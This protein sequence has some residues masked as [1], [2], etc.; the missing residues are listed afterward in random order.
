MSATENANLC[1]WKSCSEEQAVGKTARD[2]QTTEETAK[3]NKRTD[4][5]TA[6]KRKE[7]SPEVDESE[8]YW[9]SKR[10]H[11]TA[12]VLRMP[13]GRAHNVQK[14][15]E[16][17][18]KF[19]KKKG[20]AGTTRG[21]EGANSGSVVCQNT[22]G[23]D[24]VGRISKA[25]LRIHVYPRIFVHDRKCS[26]HCAR[27]PPYTYVRTHLH[28]GHVNKHMHLGSVQ[29]ICVDRAL[30]TSLHVGILDM[31]SCLLSHVPVSRES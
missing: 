1:G 19:T 15:V 16:G 4:E 30:R 25:D 11:A 23:D 31:G 12:E 24:D 2:A 18:K 26:L 7:A 13:H 6:L 27:S 5:K 10:T 14:R 17:K 29:A 21:K 28:S 20:K 22:Q 8:K 9:R 3:R